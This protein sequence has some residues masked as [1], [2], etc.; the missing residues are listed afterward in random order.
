MLTAPAN[1]ALIL[2]IDNYT[3]DELSFSISG[4]FDSD[5]IGDSKKYLAI[6][7]DWSNNV[8]IHTELFTYGPAI[9]LNTITIGS[10]THDTVVQNGIDSWKDNVFFRYSVPIITA[11]TSVSG[12]MTLSGIG[13]FNPADAATLQLV[14]G[15]N[16]PYPG[17]LQHDWARLEATAH[18]VPTPP[19]LWLFG[20]G[21]IGLV[22][23]AR[24]KAA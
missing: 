3:T 5:T 8:G 19:V 16:R 12:S 15:F 4:I 24:R 11:G 14:S 10:L 21:L 1:A 13:A 17:G 20:S 2:T 6:K 23:M 22:V 18:T 7:N 9:T